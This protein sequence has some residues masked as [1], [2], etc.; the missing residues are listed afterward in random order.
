MPTRRAVLYARVSGDD[1]HNESR[2]LNGQLDMCRAYAQ[3]HG[4]EI[5]AEL[6]EDDR[7][8]SG[9]A[10][11]LPQLNRVRELAQGHGFDVLI[12]RELDRLSRNL[13]KQLIVEEDLKRAKVAIE[14]VLGEYPDT[15]E[16]SLMKNIRAVIAEY[17]R[18]KIVE[19]TTRARRLKVATGSVLVQGRPPYGYDVVQQDDG[20][21]MLEIVEEQAAIVR[22]IFGWYV[23]GENGHG[24]LSMRTI[25]RRLSQL[26]VPTAQDERDVGHAKK[27]ARG[28][29]PQSTIHKILTNETYRGVWR[30]R[31]QIDQDGR[32][33]RGKL[34]ETIAVQV[35]AIISDE[36]WE[37]CQARRLTARDRSPRSLSHEYLMRRRLVCGRC[38]VKLVADPA[39]QYQYY[40]CPA[41]KPKQMTHPHQCDLPGFRSLFLDQV[42]WEWLK[43]MVLDPVTL[44]LGLRRMQETEVDTLA[45]VRARLAEVEQT[46]AATQGELSRLTALY[47]RGKIPEDILDRTS[48]ELTGRL[49]GLRQERADLELQLGA[50]PLTAE[51]IAD[52]L[53]I[54]EDIRTHLAG[55]DDFNLRQF[56]VEKLQ[57]EGVV[58]LDP[59]GK[60]VIDVKCRLRKGERLRVVPMTIGAHGDKAENGIVLAARLEVRRVA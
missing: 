40:R 6:A 32:R 57:V 47:V 7:G 29:W 9:A 56:V 25:Q 10:F 42:V 36:L 23:I 33:Q 3:Q 18:L 38:G 34:S 8:A 54:A 51:S 59:G 52:L 28:E 1:R 15:P 26:R 30:Y 55:G 19:R 41:S 35:P 45:P 16:G 43:S 50:G 49:A 20:R 4:Y 5:V 17:E 53:Q 46:L 58:S 2:N 39:S 12:T 44:E 13:A 14:Y 21:Y 60:R 24:P 37:K 48:E 11:E 22:R 31:K 27:R